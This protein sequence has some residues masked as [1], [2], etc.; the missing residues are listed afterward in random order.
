MAAP[1]VL[2]DTTFSGKNIAAGA[3]VYEYTAVAN[4]KIRVQVRLAAVAGG[5]DYVLHITLNDGDAQTDD[6]IG[7]RTTY[8]AAAGETA[9]WMVSGDLDL[10]AGDVINVMVDGLAG[11][12]NESGTI[13]ILADDYSVAGDEMLLT[14]AYDAAKN[15]VLTPLAVVDALVDAIKAKTDNLPSDPADQLSLDAA[16]ALLA[17]AANLAVVDGIVDAIKAKTDLLPASPAATGDIPTATQIADAVLND[18]GA[19]NTGLIPTKLNLIAADGFDVISPVA[20]SGDVTTYQ[21]DSY[22]NSDSRALE[23]TNDDWPTLTSGS[24]VIRVS[25]LEFT[26][27]IPSAKVVRLELTAAQS[28][29]IPEGNNA[30]Q[31]IATLSSTRVVTLVDAY[32][33]SVAKMAKE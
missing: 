7:P 16:L 17:T 29:T 15:D 18:T 24:V 11:D 32:W 30:F 27:S 33:R 3:S 20:D 14:A 5:G 4:C 23:W 12:T 25:G 10:L 22:N 8:S 1:T 6:A 31:V 9:F 21:G 26:G 28:A 13:R 2:I 19:G